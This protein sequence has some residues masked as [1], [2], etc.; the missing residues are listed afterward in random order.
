MRQVK[1]QYSFEKKGMDE[2]PG[3]E[4]ALRDVLKPLETHLVETLGV[5]WGYNVDKAEY[6]SR[7][8]FIPYKHNCGGIQIG[9]HLPVNEKY[10]FDFVDWEYG[11]E[12]DDDVCDHENCDGHCDGFLSVWL[13][14]EGVENGVGKFY[15]VASAGTQ[16]APYFRISKLPTIFEV[17]FEAKNMTEVRKQGA[18]AVKKLIKALK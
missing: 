15:L 3:L 18:I 11:I 17:E 12:S 4:K 8:G 1:M 10:Q 2:T 5:Y 6:K 9:V 13:K 14:F 7:D 16:D